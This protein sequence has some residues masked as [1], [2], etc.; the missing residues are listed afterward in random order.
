MDVTK[1][2]TKGQVVI[3]EKLRRHYKAGSAFVVSKIDELLVLKPIKGLTKK[4]K[5][6]VKELK[7]IWKEI[8][9]GKADVYSEKEF[10]TAMK[11]W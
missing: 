1:L 3:P 6:E 9:S 5:E 4:E 2:S 10:F 7:S 11:K 8:D